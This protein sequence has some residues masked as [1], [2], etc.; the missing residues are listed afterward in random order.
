MKRAVIQIRATDELKA[1]AYAVAKHSKK[2]VS[3]LLRLY[4]ERAY[5]QLPR[6]VK[7]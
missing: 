7:K 2:D 4:I 3:T 1:K 6:E 5:R